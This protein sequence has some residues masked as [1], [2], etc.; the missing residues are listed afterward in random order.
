MIKQR[1][2]LILGAGASLDYGYPLGRTMQ[3]QILL[4]IGES[5]NPGGSAR[6]LSDAGFNGALISE[7]RSALSESGFDTIDQLLEHRGDLVEIGKTAIA[8]NL[9]RFEDPARLHQQNGWYKY[10][11]SRYLNSPVKALCD[12]PISFIT[13]NYDRSL[14]EFLF[15][16]IKAIHQNNRRRNGSTG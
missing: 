13:F 9:I 16:S 11:F 6:A 7:L 15:R 4:E 1:T 12:I 3:D 2:V 10:F 8:C 5:G 14:E